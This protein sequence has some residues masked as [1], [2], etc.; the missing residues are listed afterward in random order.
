MNPFTSVINAFKKRKQPKIV[1]LSRDEEY[2]EGV[3]QQHGQEALAQARKV[4]RAENTLDR[5]DETI[6]GYSENPQYR[7]FFKHMIRGLEVHKEKLG[8]SRD[9]DLRDFE[10]S[11]KL[12]QRM[13]AEKPPTPLPEELERYIKEFI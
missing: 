4:L 10:L 8:E 12:E 11:K 2:L 3:R 6:G 1:P 13:T 5:V 9:K 7:E